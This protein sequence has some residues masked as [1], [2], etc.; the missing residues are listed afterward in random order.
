MLASRTA[1]VQSVRNGTRAL[2]R[3]RCLALDPDLRSGAGLAAAACTVRGELA[4]P[5]QPSGSL[6]I[7]LSIGE[8]AGAALGHASSLASH[9]NGNKPRG[10]SAVSLSRYASV[11][12]AMPDGSLLSGFR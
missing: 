3:S 7:R 2:R 10:T 11:G 6:S 1:L 9:A 5:A 12:R 4:D 8:I